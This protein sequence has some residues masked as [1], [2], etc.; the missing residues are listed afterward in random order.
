MHR[1]KTKPTYVERTLFGD[2]TGDSIRN[3]VTTELGNIGALL[4]WEHLQPLLKYHTYSQNEQIHIASWPLCPK[5]DGWNHWS[6]ST[7]ACT[8]ASRAYA[9]ES[10]AFTVVATQCRAK[11]LV[12]ESGAP[13]IPSGGGFSAIYG[14]DGR[15]LTKDVPEDWE[16]ILYA[17]CDFKDI[18]FAK[19]LFDPVG[20]YS[21]PDLLRLQADTQ[22]KESVI[23]PDASKR[24][25]SMIYKFRETELT[26]GKFGAGADTT[27]D[28]TAGAKQ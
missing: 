11:D 7:E 13:A 18:Q 8:T 15:K 24:H 23:R 19:W 2:G 5:F 25:D 17:T 14:P 28:V 16:G 9:M 22:R 1:H 27:P 21:R 10:G 12:D 3:V 4:C 6:L 26:E 20:H